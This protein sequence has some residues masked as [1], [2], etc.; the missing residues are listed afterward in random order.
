M[1]LLAHASGFK[2]PFKSINE[3]MRCGRE[4]ALGGDPACT[5]TPSNPDFDAY[6][7]TSGGSNPVASVAELIDLIRK[8]PVG[9]IDEL[10]IIGH[11]SATIFALAGTVL[12]R[13]PNSVCKFD[14][15]TARIEDSPAF[16]KNF[17]T[18]HQLRDRFSDRG[19]IT[20]VGCGNGAPGSA[21]L[22]LASKAFLVAVNGF[23]RPIQYAIDFG[24]PGKVS[25]K[26][27]RDILNMP[28]WVLN[29][30]GSLSAS[31]SG[32]RES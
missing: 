30:R 7:K 23:Q 29:W 15:E 11:S 3:E 28:G 18:L 17:P 4:S 21:L 13:D 31:G 14:V 12:I 8:Q 1:K 26:H 6:G 2:Y 20:L 9:S 10:R 19:E 5:W 24:H 16:Q 25:A 27:Q 22:E 32:S